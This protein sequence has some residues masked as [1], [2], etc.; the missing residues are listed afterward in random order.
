MK[1]NWEKITPLEFENLCYDLLYAL[2]FRNLDRRGGTSDR[3]QDIEAIWEIKDPSGDV[4]LQKWFVECKFYK[5]GLS[6]REI[7]DEIQWADAE[8]PDVLLIITNS[9]LTAQAKDW[10]EKLR[11]EK[12]YTIQIWENEKIEKLLLKHP[13]I[14]EKYFPK[15]EVEI[16]FTP[17]LISIINENQKILEDYI[18]LNISYQTFS[19]EKKVS[20]IDK[21]IENYH[22]LI[23]IGE[24]GCGKTTTLRYLSSLFANS[25]LTE[26][27]G[28]FLI[29]IYFGLR[30]PEKCRLVDSIVERIQSADLNVT[31]E[32]IED[33]LNRG[34]FIILLDGL[35]ELLKY[36]DSLDH[37]QNFITAF[38]KNRFVISSRQL[39]RI[40]VD[41][42]VGNILPLNDKQVEELITKYVKRY[43]TEFPP[44]KD[45]KLFDFMRTPL[46]IKYVAK[47]Y[48]SQKIFSIEELLPIKESLRFLFEKTWGKEKS[49]ISP[50][51]KSKILSRIA[52]KSHFL[53][54]VEL[55]EN[56]VKEIIRICLSESLGKKGK[57]YSEI[58]IINYFIDQGIL[59]RI[60]EEIT[61]THD[62]FQEY[63]YEKGLKEEQQKKG[64]ELRPTVFRNAYLEFEKMINNANL[65]E[66]DFQ[67]F[68]E[69]NPCFFGGEYIEAYPQKRAGAELIEDFLLEKY[70]GFHDVVEIKRPDHKIFVRQKRNNLKPSSECMWGVSRIMDYLDYYERNVQEEYWRTGKEIYKPRGIVV[71]GRNQ[72]IDKRKLRQLNSYLSSIEIWT[73]DDLLIKS[74]K[75]MELID[76]GTD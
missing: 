13:S 71:I 64:K 2:G 20:K 11:E 8:R 12:V 6:I 19:R 5:L 73:Y 59:I 44:M 14:L 72:N 4:Y 54:R 9:H 60:D 1:L 43:G 37:I 58:G 28:S 34:K 15:P 70:D 10:L 75:L 68:L 7:Y 50:K 48:Q 49:D 66:K 22:K 67:K 76:K 33:Y 74:K 32:I 31:R 3:G 29:P 53:I 41:A 27:Q 18:P 24:P 51:I 21:L 61:F 25:I 16:D 56:E 45:R 35:T 30:F 39:P 57:Q 42:L 36:E 52:L 62:L 26:K 47:L 55:P 23:L 65:K 38:Y 40:D 69:K 46:T 63:F 17:Y